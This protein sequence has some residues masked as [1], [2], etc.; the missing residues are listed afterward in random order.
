M[1]KNKRNERGITLIALVVTIVVLLILAGVSISMLS[2]ENGIITQAQE[3]KNNTEAAKLKEELN[4]KITEG[5]INKY[6]IGD[7]TL[8]PVFDSLNVVGINKLIEDENSIKFHLVLLENGKYYNAEYRM[9]EQSNSFEDISTVSGLREEAKLLFKLL[10]GDVDDL[11]FT[12]N[13]SFKYNGINYQIIQNRTPNYIEMYVEKI[14]DIPALK[15][16]VNSGDDGIVVLPINVEKCDVEGGYQIEWGDGKTGKD[17]T[18]VAQGNKLASTKPIYVGSGIEDGIAH[19]Y[20]EKN[21]EYEITITGTCT[22]INSGYGGCTQEKILEIKQWGETGLQFINLRGCE[23][24]RKIASP[25]ENSFVNITSFDGAF[26]WCTSLTEIPEDLFANCLNVTSFNA[27]FLWCTSLT[28]IPEGLFANCPNIT[29]FSGMFASCTGLTGEAPELWTRGTNT[30]ENGYMGNPDGESC[31]D[32]CTGLT[33][34]D[35][36]PDYWKRQRK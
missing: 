16:L 36:I 11:E 21:K 2:G 22:H 13:N 28:E 35:N 18:V 8:P 24:L 9:T 5:V 26:S 20:S 14:G 34:Y 23:N 3:A 19:T 30:E 32:S 25:S 6:T 15:F 33:N 17:G 27:T 10:K 7:E 29:D 31:F 1:E 12:S 4:L